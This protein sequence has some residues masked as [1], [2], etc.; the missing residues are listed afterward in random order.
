[1]RLLSRRY[2]PNPSQ[3]PPSQSFAFPFTICN[4]PSE[5]ELT[6]A[7]VTKFSDSNDFPFH[8]IPPFAI[9]ILE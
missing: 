5:Q 6:H 3:K 9:L 1:M 2:S 4:A 7:P 8:D